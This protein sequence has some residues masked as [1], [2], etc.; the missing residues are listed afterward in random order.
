MDSIGATVYTFTESGSSDCTIFGSSRLGTSD[1]AAGILA[2]VSL[3]ER[4]RWVLA[5]RP[6]HDGRE[7]KPTP[8][9]V[10]AGLGRNHLA[11]ILDGRVANPDLATMEAVAR[12]VGVSPAWLALGV[13]TPDDPSSAADQRPA[14]P[15][16]FGELASWRD[17][18]SGA[19]VRRPTMPAWV[20]DRVARSFPLEGASPTVAAVI[21]AADGI[22]EQ[23]PPP[24]SESRPRA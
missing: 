13:G 5:N 18:L 16:R 10:A 24:P 8:L 4:L 15:P 3:P 6:R 7:W 19:K 9:S 2:S 17:L 22:L 12:V 23:T 1:C 11:Q 20:W 21:H 14:G